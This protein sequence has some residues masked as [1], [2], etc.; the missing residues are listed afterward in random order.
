MT[1]APSHLIRLPAGRV[2]VLRV[3]AGRRCY[4]LDYEVHPDE[5]MCA[6]CGCTN[7]FGCAGGCHW[8]DLAHTVCSRCFKREMLP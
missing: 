4:A 8:V 3:F 6:T 2:R 7:I 1:E 5:D